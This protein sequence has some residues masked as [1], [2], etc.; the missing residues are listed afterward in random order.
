MRELADGLSARGIPVLRFDYR[1][2]GDS[3]GGDGA[4][5]QFETAVTDVCAAIERLREETGVTHVTLCGLRLG[6]AFMLVAAGQVR[7]DE[8]VMLAP[9]VNGR[10]YLR[11]L[12]IVR[13]IWLEQLPVPLRAVQQHDAS[14]NVLGQV[15]SAAFCD[16][17]KGFDAAAA[18]KG[19]TRPPASRT[20]VFDVHPA[21]SESMRA[22]IHA[23]GGVA[24][25]RSFD[26]Y[27]AFMQESV[28]SKVPERVFDAVLDWI[29]APMGTHA[30]ATDVASRA[31]APWP[32]PGPSTVLHMTDVYEQPVR[33]GD[34]GLF[35]ILCVPSGSP[36]P[37]SAL[38]ITNTSASPHVG[39]SRL[40][41]RIA[42]ELARRGIASLRFDA[43]GIGDGAVSCAMAA[44]M[45]LQ[46]VYSKTTVEDAA[47]AADWLKA[48]GY[49]NV[50]A[51]GICSGAYSALRAGLLGRSLSGVVSVNLQSFYI[52]EG[53]SVESLHR[54]QSNSI[55]GY[56]SSLFDLSKWVQVLRGERRIWPFVRLI[57]KRTGTM[58][59]KRVAAS[60]FWITQSSAVDAVPTD[61]HEVM[62]V[63]QRNGVSTLFVCGAYDSSLD[64]MTMHFGR[65]GK[66]LSKFRSARAM[67]LD[68]VDHSLFGGQAVDKVVAL[69]AEFTQRLDAGHAAIGKPAGRELPGRYRRPQ[70]PT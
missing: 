61:P 13:N 32:D 41:V 18:L 33:F 16:R 68:E 43:R 44:R 53:V 9:V 40:S 2:T 12:S 17:L 21:D 55:A 29:S 22:G 51:F 10:A 48:R 67:V 69:C 15:Y 57:L 24:E 28:F 25:S 54:Y 70:V 23:L 8:L 64:L 47:A 62:R 7:V 52:P 30:S 31:A 3:A 50:V 65:R 11:E 20:L 19:S 5:D 63:L 38:L 58:L 14:F 35:G 45:A 27:G 4:S 37:G 39:D 66:R 59:S 42:R 1:G 60:R 56:R 6:A 46:P 49:R 34:H 36:D 26:G